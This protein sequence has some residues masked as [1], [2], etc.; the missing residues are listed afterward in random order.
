VLG[1]HAELAVVAAEL[2]QEGLE[3]VGLVDHLHDVHERAHEAAALHLHVDGEQVPALGRDPEEGGVEEP[4]HLFGM[5][6]HLGP[7]VPDELG[8]ALLLTPRRTDAGQVSGEQLFSGHGG[9]L[10][11]ARRCGERGTGVQPR[12]LIARGANR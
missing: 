5:I 10:L 3:H 12:Q 9:R 8:P 11:P 7:A 1:D 6:F 2:L 4:P